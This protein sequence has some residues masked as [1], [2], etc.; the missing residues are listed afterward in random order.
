MY[1]VTN[2]LK[3]KAVVEDN[4]GTMY[5]GGGNWGTLSSKCDI[6]KSDIYYIHRLAKINHVYLMNIRSD[7]TNPTSITKEIRSI[8]NTGE[9][10]DVFN[11]N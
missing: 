2:S 3:D 9:T 10:L 11:L 8:T 1:K 6:E 4:K 7:P 5:F